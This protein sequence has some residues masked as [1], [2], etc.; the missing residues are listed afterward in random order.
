[1]NYFLTLAQFLLK[2]ILYLWQM[3]DRAS[4][5]ETK[6]FQKY[7][8]I[9]F[10]IYMYQI[11]IPLCNFC[12]CFSNFR[13]SHSTIFQINK[14]LTKLHRTKQFDWS[15]RWSTPA[16]KS[17]AQEGYLCTVSWSTEVFHFS[18]ILLNLTKSCLKS[19]F[20]YSTPVIR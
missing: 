12:H 19:V 14:Y 8:F 17:G 15:R 3:T 13:F 20:I 18:I 7:T 10:I 11:R 16:A 5:A 2:T 4:V 1:M 9:I 6:M